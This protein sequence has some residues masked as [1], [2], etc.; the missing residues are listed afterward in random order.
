MIKKLLYNLLFFFAL[1]AILFALG[2]KKEYSYEGGAIQNYPILPDSTIAGDTTQIIN[3]IPN[4][5]GCNSIDEAVDLKWSFKVGNSSLC[6]NV[7]RGVLSPDGDG[8][9][10]FGPSTCSR[11]S[12]LIITAF[13]S[14]QVLNHDQNNLTASRASLEYYDNITMS[15][16]LHSKRPNIFSLTIDNY[17]HQTGVVTGTFYGSVLDKNGKIIKVESGKFSA[18]F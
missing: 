13:F 10:F 12:G 11:D 2:C 3:T 5:D 18:R 16:V 6:G 15:D 1:Y 4:C 7:T 17:V 9:T 8:M 14:G